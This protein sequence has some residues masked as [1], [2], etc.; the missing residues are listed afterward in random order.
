MSTHVFSM[1]AAAIAAAA[2]FLWRWLRRR[3]PKGE[4]P[5][6]SLVELA[7]QDQSAAPKHKHASHKHAAKRRG[8]P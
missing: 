3:P 8:E 5:L 4:S 2:V 6:E 1:A 7:E